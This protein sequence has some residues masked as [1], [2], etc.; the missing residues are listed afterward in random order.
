MED[1]DGLLDELY[2]GNATFT[3]TTSSGPS[4]EEMRLQTL[5]RQLEADKAE[6]QKKVLL[7]RFVL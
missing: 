6:L 1:D 3:L 2:G 5:C 4:D 7:G